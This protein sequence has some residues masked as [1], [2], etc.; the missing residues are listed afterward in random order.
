MNVELKQINTNK[1]TGNLNDDSLDRNEEEYYKYKK[2]SK[3][4]YAWNYFLIFLPVIIIYSLILV[5]YVGYLTTYISILINSSNYDSSDYPFQSTSDFKNG[6]GKGLALLILSSIFFVLLLISITRT[7]FMNPGYYPSPLELEQKLIDSQTVKEDSDKN[8]ELTLNKLQ[9]KNQTTNFIHQND[10]TQIKK[11]KLNRTIFQELDK[12]FNI[13]QLHDQTLGLD[14]HEINEYA[15]KNEFLTAFNNII[16]SKPLTFTENNELRKKISIYMDNEV[17]VV[18][19]KNFDNI[20]LEDFETRFKCLEFNKIIFCSICLRMK[21]ERSHHC[22]QCGKCVLKMDHHCPWLAN[23]IGFYNYKYFILTD[24]HGL[25]SCIIVLTTFWEAVIGHNISGT[26]SLGLCFF[27][28]FS[29]SCVLGLFAFLIWLG[30]LNLKLIFT[31]Q[32]VIEN[33][34]KERFPSTKTINIYDTGVYN[35]L[36]SVLGSNPLIWLLPFWANYEGKGFTFKTIYDIHEHE[37]H[38]TQENKS[39]IPSNQS[40]NM[41]NMNEKQK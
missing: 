26:A 11:D 27:T 9:E 24:I 4:S 16:L 13:N 21:V 15:N 18:N 32:S 10:R 35:N 23:C 1:E 34:D 3:F 20:D 37:G 38:E 41:V 17:Q 22:R 29:Y 39:L 7:V 5:G 33:A 14:D 19:R 30:Y 2:T 36:C 28:T 6:Y 8:I 25:I 12:S 31:N 40:I